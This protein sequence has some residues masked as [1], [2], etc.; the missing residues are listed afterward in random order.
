[1]V[2]DIQYLENDKETHWKILQKKWHL[3]FIVRRWNLRVMGIEE[4]M[5]KGIENI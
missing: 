5:L 1:M 2:D 4:D 3:L